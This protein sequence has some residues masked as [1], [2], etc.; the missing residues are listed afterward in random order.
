MDIITCVN[1]TFK[2]IYIQ[3]AFIYVIFISYNLIE[4]PIF[5][6][7]SLFFTWLISNAVI[8]IHLKRSCVFNTISRLMMPNMNNTLN[9]NDAFG[10][11]SKLRYSIKYYVVILIMLLVLFLIGLFNRLGLVDIYKIVMLINKQDY[12][13][14]IIFINVL[15]LLTILTIIFQNNKSIATICHG[16]MPELAFSI[17][18]IV[19]TLFFVKGKYYQFVK[20]TVSVNSISKNDESINNDEVEYNII[21]DEFE[22]AINSVNNKNVK[23]NIYNTEYTNNGNYNIF[24]EFIAKSNDIIVNRHVNSIAYEVER[25]NKL[26]LKD[27]MTLR[28]EREKKEYIIP[29]IF[30]L[31]LISTLIHKIVLGKNIVMLE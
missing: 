29:V 15:L 23:A 19:V 10:S 7:H 22:S 12:S 1:K 25:S 5:I 26:I 16:P 3:I 11:L 21:I 27:N 13:I 9:S 30:I 24:V 20:Y 28:A 18:I 17:F 14:M 8:Y 6:R 4:M 2:Y 31:L